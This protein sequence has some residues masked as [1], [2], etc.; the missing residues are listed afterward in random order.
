MCQE[1]ESGLARRLKIS[2]KTIV[3]WRLDW[4]WSI[5]SNMAHACSHWQKVLVPAHHWQ[6][7]SYLPHRPPCSIS[8]VFQRSG[9]LPLELL[10]SLPHPHSQADTNGDIIKSF[11]TEK[12]EEFLGQSFF[13]VIIIY[14]KPHGK[15][16]IKTK[17]WARES[18]REM[19]WK[20]SIFWLKI[21]YIC[22]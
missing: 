2:A 9:F 11:Y 19:V 22:A 17:I 7:F 1:F 10:G 5:L 15:I 18:R 13:K 3:V 20:Y 16:K 4:I 6:E 14:M 12:S 8:W 21:I